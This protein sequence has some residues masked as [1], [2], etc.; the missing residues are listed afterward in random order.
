[1]GLEQFPRNIVELECKVRRVCCISQD[2]C[3]E[4]EPVGTYIQGFNVGF[5]FTPIGTSWS[6]P[7]STGMPRRAAGR[8]KAGG[9]SS[10][11]PGFQLVR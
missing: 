6:S 7:K 10:A 4:T 8:V 5:A 2:S 9:S 3:R 11:L 1:M